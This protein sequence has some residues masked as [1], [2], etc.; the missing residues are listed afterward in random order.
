MKI[1]LT[2][3]QLN[4]VVK[5]QQK[6]DAILIGGLDN[7][8]VV[9]KKTGKRVLIDKTLD[10]QIS[11]LQDASGLDNIMGFRYNA[12]NDDIKSTIEN[13]PNIPVVL[14]SKG[15]ERT[16]VV[17]SCNG[18]NSNN[19]FVIQP[20]AGSKNMLRYYNNLSIPKKNIYVGKTSSAGYGIS[21]ATPCPD[22]MGHWESLP[23]I[24]AM[25]L[26]KKINN[27]PPSK[28]VTKKVSKIGLSDLIY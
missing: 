19:V 12:P 9:D 10:Q 25:V 1:L 2:E 28:V 15:C 13:N 16:D 18:V 22:G 24:G 26:N 27:T 11:L 3:S 17:L 5:D 23:K 8:T 7:R 6:Y 14:F 4:T 21:G 20:W